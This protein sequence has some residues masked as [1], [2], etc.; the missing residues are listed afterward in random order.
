M[1]IYLATPPVNNKKIAEYIPNAVFVTIP[2]AGHSTAIEKPQE[3]VKA[4][5]V[6]YGELMT[7]S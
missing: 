5:K 3:I 6:F 4:M 1:A 7:I 2:D